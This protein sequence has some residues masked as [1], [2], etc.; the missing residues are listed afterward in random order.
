VLDLKVRCSK[1]IGSL[2]G[3][4]ECKLYISSAD[5]LETLDTISEAPRLPSLPEDAF[6]PAK[7]DAT[8][9]MYE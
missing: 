7:L 6:D 8:E 1:T 2:P 5:S 4:I 9:T 3:C